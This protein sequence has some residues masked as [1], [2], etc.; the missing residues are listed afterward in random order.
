MVDPQDEDAGW[1]L[2]VA[3]DV[4]GA[5][6]VLV[7][8]TLPR[9]LG[10]FRRLGADAASAEDL[11][12]DVYLKLYRGRASYEPRARFSTYLLR[13]ARNHWIDVY[14]HKRLGPG[15]VSTELRR[16]GGEEE[17]QS[18]GAGLEGPSVDPARG[19]T[20]PELRRALEQ[21]LGELEAVS[22]EVFVLAHVHGLPYDEIALVLEIPVGTVKSRVHAATRQLRD[23]LRRRGIEP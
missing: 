3:S 20:Q 10:F 13:V 16:G 23:I 21:G 7:S 18:L 9:L 8:R 5:F 14:R 17:G 11:A 4:P 19:A 6:E 1:M 15:T 2:K 12:Q 22:R